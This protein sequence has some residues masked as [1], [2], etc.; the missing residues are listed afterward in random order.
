[1]KDRSLHKLT[2]SF[3]SGTVDLHRLD[4]DLYA[5]TDPSGNVVRGNGNDVLTLLFERAVE[6]ATGP[7][8][9]NVSERRS[10]TLDEYDR[11]YAGG[12]TGSFNQLC[13][14]YNAY[15]N[16]LQKKE[17]FEP[18]CEDN[19]CD[20]FKGRPFKIIGRCKPCK[21]A[22]AYTACL[23]MWEIRFDDGTVLEVFPS[24][25]FNTSNLPGAH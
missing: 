1:M 18:L 25:I 22:P 19:L 11:K 12:G 9:A 17:V 13:D 16:S 2:I 21:S 5:F 23:P 10:I 20:L 8:P 7:D 3:G 14:L 24:E 6:Y 15:E 4:Y